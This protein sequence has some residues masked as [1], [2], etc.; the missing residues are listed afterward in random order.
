MRSQNGWDASPSLAL[1]PLVVNGVGFL[2]GIRDDDDVETVLRH[3]WTEYAARVEPLRN[4]G[5]WGF[6][7][8]ENRN[9]PNALSNHASGTATD[10]NAPAHPNGV[11]TAST[12]TADQIAEVHA[13][14]AELD[15]VLRWGGDYTGTPD[16]MHVEVNVDPETLH[17][18]AERLRGD[19]TMNSTQDE[20]L[21]A[22]EAATQR[23]ESDLIKV[24][25]VVRKK[26]A[27]AWERD[28]D[29]KALIREVLAE[30]KDQP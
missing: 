13:I 3:F 12:F 25:A 24:L 27:N 15:H 4:P 9:D 16:A 19:A 26:G 30:V 28:V 29:L 2:P 8:R 21:K 17:A 18:T 1:R 10:G 11:P 20:R 14:L 7:Y 23:I 6:S 22:V 5:C